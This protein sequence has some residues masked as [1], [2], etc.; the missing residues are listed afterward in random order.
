MLGFISVLLQATLIIAELFAHNLLS[1]VDL[2]W[3]KGV[4]SQLGM[5]LKIVV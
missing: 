5:V 1:H 4:E 3:Y 2:C